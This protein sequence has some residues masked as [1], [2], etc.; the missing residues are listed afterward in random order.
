MTAPARPAVDRGQAMPGVVRSAHAKFTEAPPA[1][2]DEARLGSTNEELGASFE[3]AAHAVRSNAGGLVLV[4]LGFIGV[5]AAAGVAAVLIATLSA[6][7]RFASITFFGWMVAILVFVAGLLWGQ[8][9]LSRSWS[10]VVRGAPIGFGE[11]F[12]L[13]SFPQMVLTWMLLIPAVG[14]LGGIPFPF[15]LTSIEFIAGDDMT[16][17]QAIGRMFS[18]EFSSFRRFAHTLV[19][20]LIGWSMNVVVVLTTYVLMA[21]LM[22]ASWSSLLMNAFGDSYNRVTE[23]ELQ[24]T[25]TF[26]STG[27]AIFAV[28]MASAAYHLIGLWTAGRARLL[29]DR[30][31]GA[32]ALTS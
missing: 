8:L 11:A 15:L 24:W 7:T 19:V 26:G 6:L 28:A 5:L 12:S 14:L 29:T 27:V 1:W 30:P 21:G 10:M 9:A 4:S 13:R 22:G 2:A 20:G 18:E 23:T 17:S 3:W 25:V 32:R 16:T 31:L